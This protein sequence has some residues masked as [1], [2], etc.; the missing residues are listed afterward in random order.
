MEMSSFMGCKDIIKIISLDDDVIEVKLELTDN[1]RNLLDLLR[2]QV[3]I[4]DWCIT[5]PENIYEI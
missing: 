3:F 2:L 5:E 4:K 1:I